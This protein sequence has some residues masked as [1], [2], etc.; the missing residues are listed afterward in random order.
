MN[1]CRNFRHRLSSAARLPVL[2]DAKTGGSFSVMCEPEI[3]G[4]RDTAKDPLMGFNVGFHVRFNV[5]FSEIPIF[6]VLV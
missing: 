4:F 2:A 6:V 3:P 1:Y 5:S